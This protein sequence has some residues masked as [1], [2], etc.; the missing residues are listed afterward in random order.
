[1]EAEHIWTDI[2]L[3]EAHHSTALEGNTLV[4]KQVELLLSE[5]LAVGN[6]ELR[7][8]NEVKGYADAANWVY[9]QAIAPGGVRGRSADPHRASPGACDGDDAGLGRRAAS[10]RDPSRGA[11]QLP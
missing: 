6:K 9:R 11:R 1:M 8:Y 10:G 7:E 3:K 4:L 2:W 5:G